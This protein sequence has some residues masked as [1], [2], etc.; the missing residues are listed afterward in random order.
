MPKVL[1]PVEASA[2]ASFQVVK[3]NKIETLQSRFSRSYYV[4]SDNTSQNEVDIANT[5]GIPPLYSILGGAWCVKIDPKEIATIGRHPTTGVTCILY[6]VRCDFD[7]D[8]DVQ[9]ANQAPTAKTPKVSWTGEL[10]EDVLE[11]DAI[12]GY[13]IQTVPG[14][15]IPETGP[16]PIAILEVRRYEYP[17]FNPGVMLAYA[18]H[19]NST[20]FYGAPSGTA[21][22]MPMTVSEVQVVNNTR[23]VEVAYQIKFKIKKNSSGALEQD[24]WASRPLHEGYKFFPEVGKPA[25]IARD[26]FGNPRTVNLKQD[27]TKLP[28][29]APLNQLFFLTFNRFP[30]ANFNFLNL[31]P[32]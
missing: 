1:G 27:G 19:T 20:P 32:Y 22:M 24:T 4:L 23:V 9:E 25:E 28:D 16:F 17:P 31:G 8:T 26:K 13:P 2:L 5:A 30:K 12:T 6:E 14:E 3:K 11:K 29:N 21:L 18:A 7:S 15:P 10:E